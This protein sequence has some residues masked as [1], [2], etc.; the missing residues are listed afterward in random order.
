ML[1]VPDVSVAVGDEVTPPSVPPVS[2]P[3]VS[4]HCQLNLQDSLAE[5]DGLVSVSLG[6]GLGDGLVNVAL[7]VGARLGLGTSL[8]ISPMGSGGGKFIGGEFFSASAM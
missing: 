3:P 8:T 2:V 7:G 6:V 5:G 1:P 4:V